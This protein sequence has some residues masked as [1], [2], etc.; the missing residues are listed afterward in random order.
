MRQT[1]VL[2]ASAA[3]ALTH[4][5]PLL[6]M[7]HALTRKLESGLEE[8]GAEITIRAE[9]CMVKFS[10]HLTSHACVSHHTYGDQVFYNPEPIG[11]EY[12]EIADRARELPEPIVLGGARLVVHIQ[13]TEAAVDDFLAVVREL[14]E[15]KRRAGFVRPKV[16][17]GNGLPLKDIYVRRSAKSIK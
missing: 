3:Y 4:N 1:G 6:P 15:E 17:Q 12:G 16:K 14:A 13:T 7:V 9:T 2:A 10:R 5:F 8:I 11:V